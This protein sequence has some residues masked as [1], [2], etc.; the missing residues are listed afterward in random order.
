MAERIE[1]N[2]GK[3]LAANARDV[4]AARDKGRDAAFIDRLALNEA[5]VAAMAKG[6]REIAGLP[7]PVGQ[8]MTRWTRPNGLEIS[9]VRVPIGVIGIIYE[10]RPNVTADAA[11]AVPEVRQCRDP[12]RRLRELPLLARHRQHFERGAGRGRPARGR[13]P[14]RCRRSIARRWASCSAASAAPS[15]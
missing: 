11:G 13:D 6:L 9:R 14:A 15:T 12:A 8:V 7:D 4:E 2:A 3:I 10:A 1:A 5:R